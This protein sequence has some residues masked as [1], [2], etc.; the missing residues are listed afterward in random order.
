MDK[1]SISRKRFFELKNL[2]IRFNLNVLAV[3]GTVSDAAT[4]SSSVKT[5]TGTGKNEFI[6]ISPNMIKNNDAFAI[7]G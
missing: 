4:Y 6:K 2:T 7:V 3:N 1:R 5:D